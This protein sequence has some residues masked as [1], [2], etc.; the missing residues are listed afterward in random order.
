MQVKS[1]RS[2]REVL[3]W[4]RNVHGDLNNWFTMWSASIHVLDLK[5]Y[6]R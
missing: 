1:E 5:K 2:T 4:S 6:E 3:V